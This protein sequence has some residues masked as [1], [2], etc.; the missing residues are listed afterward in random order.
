[1]KDRD[2]VGFG[3]RPATAYAS[4][5]RPGG[6]RSLGGWQPPAP[7]QTELK[8][9]GLFTSGLAFYV[10]LLSS[11]LHEFLYSYGGVHL[12]L[13]AIVF[14]VILVM[15][16]LAGNPGRF[17][18]TPFAFPWIAMLFW[19]V[20]AGLTGI[21][22]RR[23][24]AYLIPYAIRLHTLPLIIC[25]IAPDRRGLKKV[26]YS[27]GFGIILVLF[28]CFKFG[29]T[30]D[31]RFIVPNT[32]L[33]NANDLGLRLLMYGMIFLIFLRAGWPGRLLTLFTFPVLV[34]YVLR[35][36]SRSNLLTMFVLILLSIVFLPKRAKI[37]IVAL[38]IVVPLFTIPFVPRDT[39]ARLITFF[40][41]SGRAG[42]GQTDLRENAV[43]STNARIQL[44]ERAME[45]TLGHPILGVGPLNFEDGVEAM[46]R[47][48]IGSKSGWQVAH[49]SYLQVSAET[50]M[51]G[52]VFY[53]WS[54]WLC[55]YLNYRGFRDGSG[56]GYLVS[57]S[58]FLASVVYAEGV[59]FCSI[60]YDYFLALLVGL[61]AA[62]YMIRKSESQA[63]PVSA[64]PFGNTPKPRLRPAPV[65]RA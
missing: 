15:Y 17:L 65:R 53:A 13:V 16:L 1:M 25:A 18:R 57:F 55:L 63:I 38:A 24:I 5:A 36:G 7:V 14:T 40:S 19:W 20:L 44:Q 59:L 34:Y 54:I 32:S 33:A 4:P 12:P 23:S 48:T 58:L 29:R 22:P 2:L 27:A 10:F 50:G 49:D 37:W 45:L 62:N 46:V 6:G 11:L 64:N 30:V 39:A 21:Y 52:L 26:L 43:D 42:I 41:V 28:W 47:A 56:V 61:T 3:A 8:S 31:E 35:T 51:P 60:P 9:N